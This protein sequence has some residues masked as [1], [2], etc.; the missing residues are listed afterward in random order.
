MPLKQ[1][2]GVSKTAL[3]TDATYESNVQV[4][5]DAL[6]AAEVQKQNG[7]TLVIPSNGLNMVNGVNILANAPKT[8][9]YLVGELY[10]RFNFVT[11]GAETNLGFRTIVQENQDITDAEVNDIL[12]KKFEESKKCNQ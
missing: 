1:K 2:G 7:T 6:D 8:Y 9:E 12:N 3:W 10:K 5:N 11:P 4:I